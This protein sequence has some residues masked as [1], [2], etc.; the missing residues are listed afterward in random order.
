MVFPLARG[1]AKENEPK[2]LPLNPKKIVELAVQKSKEQPVLF[3][4]KLSVYAGLDG[5]P[6]EEDIIHVATTMRQDTAAFFK[7]LDVATRG[8][9]VIAADDADSI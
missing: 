1:R 3:Y 6:M 2:L 9:Y 4:G 7:S 8:F 5:W